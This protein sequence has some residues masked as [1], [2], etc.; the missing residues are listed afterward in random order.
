M[1]TIKLYRYGED[2]VLAAADKSLLG[3]TMREGEM[4]LEVSPSFYEGEDGTE[5]MLSNRLELAT[6]ANLVGE[7]TVSIAV[8]HKY[9]D[10]ECVLTIDGVPHAQMV[11]I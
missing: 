4:K 8:K 5:E 11:K 2:V 7:E 10:E 1:I 6:V 9:V 3:K